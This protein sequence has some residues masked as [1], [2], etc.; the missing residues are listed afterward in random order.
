LADVGIVVLVFATLAT[1][2]SW[3]GS[4]GGIISFGHAIFFGIGAYAVAVSNL[5]G[6]SPWYGALGGALVAV[7]VA[8][9]WALVALRGRGYAFALVTLAFGVAAQPFVAAHAWVGPHNAYAF[10]LRPSFFNLQFASKWPYLALALIVFVV[11]QAVTV[12]LRASRLS[13][14]LRALRADPVATRGIGIAAFPPRLC[15]LLASAFV[16]SVAGSFLAEYA[17]GVNAQLFAFTFACDI[18]LIGVVAGTATAWGPALAGA[19]YAL[20][21]RTVSLHPAGPLG[22]AVVVVEVGL[23]VAASVVARSG[24][25]PLRHPSGVAA[26]GAA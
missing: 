19:L 9:I 14:E 18:A 1:A 13:F 2:W 21:A 24:W 22:V 8:G 6:G 16:T 23:I 26:R 7:I 11:A 10:P 17:L 4:Y 12:G 5:R 25:S 3:P 20:L 15:A